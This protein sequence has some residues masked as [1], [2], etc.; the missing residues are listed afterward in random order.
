[1]IDYAKNFHDALERA[2]VD[3]SPTELSLAGNFYHAKLA[4]CVRWSTVND[5][6]P[7][8]TVGAVAAFS[9]GFSPENDQVALDWIYM[10]TP[11]AESKPSGL[12]IPY[13]Y[14]YFSA[15]RDI[16]DGR[17]NAESLLK[18]NVKR[19]EYYRAILG[20]PDAFVIDVHCWRTLIGAPM[21]ANIPL[22]PLTVNQYRDIRLTM[23]AAGFTSYDQAIVW[24]ARRQHTT[25]RKKA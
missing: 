17:I 22:K 13:G 11:N 5:I 18:R 3:H 12:S 6:D 24:Y 14:R 23:L 19:G 25:E 8:A 2:R 16:L 7:T 4:E 9:P 20:D 10:Y 1:M 21:G 15:A